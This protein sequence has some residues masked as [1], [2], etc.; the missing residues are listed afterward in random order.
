MIQ[1]K[2][3]WSIVTVFIL[4]SCSP[5][6]PIQSETTPTPVH[7]LPAKVDF[8]KAFKVVA[9]S[10]LPCHGRTTLPEVITRVKKAKFVE[11]EG[12]TRERIIAA[13]EGLHD[14]MKEGIPFSFTSEEE[15]KKFLATTPGEMVLM[16]EKGVMPPPW[17]LALMKEIKWSYTPL[18]V[19]ERLL[20]LRYARQNTK[21]EHLQ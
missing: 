21:K 1:K 20:L 12:E 13:L 15:V 10:C 17:A 4:L 14:D 5:E 11:I 7:S 18:E 9:S 8:T 2:L 16:L 6:E 19:N 3:G